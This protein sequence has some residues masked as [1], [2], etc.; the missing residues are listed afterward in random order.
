MN[1][2]IKSLLATAA[3][4]ALALGV[5]A[6]PAAKIV[7]VDMAAL[8]DKHYK[9]IENNAKLQSDDQ[10][11]QEELEKMNKEGNAL[12]EEYK[13]L[14]EQSSNPAL[15][16]DGKAKA[17]AEAQKKLEAIQEKQRA[18]QNFAQH[19]RNT[20]GQRLNNFRALM[21]EEIGKVATTVATRKGANIVLD[22]AGPT[23]FGISALIHADPAFD[24][25][26]DVMKEINKDRPAGAAT[27]PAP[28]AT[29]TPALTVPQIPAP[30]K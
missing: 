2:S 12:V 9:T 23:G 4:A 19:T 6:Q 25:T 15:S 18:V 21:L 11:A 5:S 29:G 1:N 30:K 14:N 28:A 22:K 24:I 20:L 10:K 17:Q 3:F 27:A 26:E 13:T 16:A 8:Y 7:V